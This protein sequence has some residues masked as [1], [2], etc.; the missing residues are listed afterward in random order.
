MPSKN[1]EIEKRLWEAADE[2]RANSKLRSSEYSTPVLG[3]VFLKWADFK[4]S[5]IEKEFRKK[6]SKSKKKRKIGKSDYQ[7][8]GVMY[9]QSHYNLTIHC[10]VG[11]C[12]SPKSSSIIVSIAFKAIL[13]QC[14]CFN[15]FD[16]YD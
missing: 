15:I 8:K 4:F 1:S 6:A 11:N 12:L 3:L 14:I 10:S 13:I 16:C 2:L 5:Q 7:A 9:L